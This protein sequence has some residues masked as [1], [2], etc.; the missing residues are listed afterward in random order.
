MR[1]VRLKAQILLLHILIILPQSF[2]FGLE[3]FNF[4]TEGLVLDFK[5]LILLAGL[6]IFELKT[7][8]FI[9]DIIESLHQLFIL[10]G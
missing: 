5:V 9:A 1:V 8:N 2:Q 10:I 6:I 4:R 3:L 7:V